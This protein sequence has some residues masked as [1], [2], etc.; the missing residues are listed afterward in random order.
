V[1]TRTD[2]DRMSAVYDAGRAFPPQ[3][4]KEWKA[5]VD[6]YLSAA[7]GPIIDVG[8]GTGI[9]S[10]LFAQWFEVHVFGVE[11]SAG[12]RREAVTKRSHPRVR[13][14]GGEGERLPLK[15]GIGAVVW[16]STVVHHLRDIEAAAHEVRRVLEPGAPVLIRSAFSGRHGDIPWIRFFPS[17][18]RLADVRHPKVEATVEAF[19]VAGFRRE[20][21]ESVSQVSAS[22]LEEYIE[23][24]ATR[25][26]STLTMISDR[27]FEKGLSAMREA[28]QQSPPGPVRTTLDL[29]VLR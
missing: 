2:Y 26:D 25:A 21:L 3:W 7:R 19:S 15:D 16:M 27:E 4:L 17:A 14:L 11:P 22:N 9:W 28:A 13:Y 24:V 12:M 23:R 8:C 10:L 20:R 29:L 5:A 18:L 6:P 1:V